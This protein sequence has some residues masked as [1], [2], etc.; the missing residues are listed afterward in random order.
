[1]TAPRPD[2]ASAE[3]ALWSRAEDALA[4][5]AVDPSG[6]G[7]V[8][9]RVAA[10]PVQDRLRAEFAA[11]LAPWETRRVPARVS[12]EALTGGLDVMATL[13]RGRLRRAPGLLAG[14]RALT[15]S[16]AERLEAPAAAALSAKLDQ[17][18]P[19]ALLAIDEGEGD[20]ALSP[21]LRERLAFHLPLRE[22]RPSAAAPPSPERI[23]AARRS[24]VE[25]KTPPE[26]FDEIAAL[27]AALGVGGLR[28]PLFALRAAR[29]S[30]ALEQRDTVAE[31]DLER[32]IRLVLAPPRRPAARPGGGGARAG[33]RAAP[34]RGG[35]SSEGRGGRG[36]R[37]EP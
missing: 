37:R 11:A 2:A 27:A 12:R 16:M 30:A 35:S 7:G 8:W 4:L 18:A 31:R 26:T 32:A 10:G 23:A 28:A 24:L 33:A 9:A 14:A 17:S 15:L 36:R 3:E 34:R 13:A 21:M 1:M 25:T 6:L 19:L 5:L 29:A 22:A 20:E